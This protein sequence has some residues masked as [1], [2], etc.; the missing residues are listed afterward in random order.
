MT[1]NERVKEIRKKAGLNQKEFGIKLGMGQGAV[2]WM[3]QI[4][5]N[6]VD[7]NK[8]M[9]CTTFNISSHWLETGEG[10]MQIQ[11][12]FDIVATLVKKYH[13]SLTQKKLMEIFLSMS[14]EKRD[15]I[16]NTFFDFV[17]AANNFENNDGITDT[18]INNAIATP[19][20]VRQKMSTEMKQAIVNAELLAEEK[21]KMS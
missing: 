4:G 13:M 2:S 10:E 1:I 15:V 12:D 3:E 5:N 18:V 20:K 11:E 19:N 9:I 6:I 17:K 21:A 14:E 7:Q 8:K 16:S